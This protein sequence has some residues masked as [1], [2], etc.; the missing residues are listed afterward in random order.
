ML[1]YLTENYIVISLNMQV[2]IKLWFWLNV[3]CSMPIQLNFV[4]RDEHK[5]QWRLSGVGGG[6]ESL[7]VVQSKR[8]FDFILSSLE[9]WTLDT[10]S[11]AF[12]KSEIAH[13]YKLKCSLKVIIFNFFLCSLNSTNNFEH[14]YFW[15]FFLPIFIVV[16]FY[17]WPRNILFKTSI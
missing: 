13:F 5:L 12:F 15:T 6:V 16:C 17:S 14:L 10:V 11:K 9:F 8:L 3:F 4:E 7:V 2:W 1:V